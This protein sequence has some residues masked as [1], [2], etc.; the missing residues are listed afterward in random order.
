[1]VLMLLRIELKETSG[2]VVRKGRKAK[3]TEHCSVFLLPKI[4]HPD[5]KISYWKHQI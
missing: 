3:K 5:R 1:M 4:I 2:K